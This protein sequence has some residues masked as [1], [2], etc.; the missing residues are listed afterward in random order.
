MTLRARTILIIGATVVSLIALLYVVSS[1]IMSAG[2]HKTEKE[3]AAGFTRVEDA[4]TRRNVSRVAD[5]L[6]QKIDNLSVKLADWAM[7]DDTYKFIIDRNKAFLESNLNADGLSALKINFILL[8][9]L[10]AERVAGMGLNCEEKKEIPLP[11]ILLKLLAPGSMLLDHKNNPESVICG[12]VLLPE[13]PL[14][15]ASRPIVKSDGTG[16]DTS[17]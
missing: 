4:N 13:G 3:L 11:E 6:N 10:K 7:W 15:I 8:F 9:N 17:V 12:M 5:A 16:P 1:H 2:L 14:M